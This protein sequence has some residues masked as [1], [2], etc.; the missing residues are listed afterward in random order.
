MRRRNFRTLR[1]PQM[2][3]Q[4]HAY[5]VDKNALVDEQEFHDATDKLVDLTDD[6]D[7]RDE[8]D[9]G[10]ED[11]AQSASDGDIDVSGFENDQDFFQVMDMLVDGEDWLLAALQDDGEEAGVT[12]V[13]QVTDAG[14]VVVIMPCYD[15]NA[16]VFGAGARL[17]H[18]TEHQQGARLNPFA[19]L[20]LK[21]VD[22][23]DGPVICSS[24]HN[25]GCNR[26]DNSKD[27]FD[28]LH[29]A[30]DQL[31]QAQ[32]SV[33]GEHEPLC[34]CASAV[35]VSRFGALG[36]SV[37]PVCN[38]GSFWSFYTQAEP[39]SALNSITVRASMRVCVYVCVLCFKL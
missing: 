22:F 9:S 34:R 18:D 36:S 10:M 29:R 25:P 13:L 30:A 28:F 24:C 27:L 4:R 26:S 15:A 38:E 16:C 32:A 5:D 6:E 31:H 35:I 7:E 39:F 12:Q 33:L 11:D 3:V 2:V 1:M 23:S 20:T 17:L 8:D 19:L 21:R 37:E 14:E